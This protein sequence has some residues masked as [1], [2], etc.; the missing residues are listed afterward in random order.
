MN[1][2]VVFGVLFGSR[3]EASMVSR[4]DLVR[5]MVVLA[6]ALVSAFALGAAVVLALGGAFTLVWFARALLLGAVF[7]GGVVFLLLQRAARVT[8]VQ[9]PLTTWRRAE[10]TQTCSIAVLCALVGLS[11]FVCGGLLEWWLEFR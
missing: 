3:V 9:G 1:Q 5:E 8:H 10:R 2:V 4:N 6:T 11:L 7:I